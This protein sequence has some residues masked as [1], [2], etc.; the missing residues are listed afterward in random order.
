M[1]V[2]EPERTAEAVRRVLPDLLRLCCYESRAAARRDRAIRG[3][4]Q[5]GLNIKAQSEISRLYRNFC[6]I[7]PISHREIRWLGIRVSR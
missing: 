1:P 4:A 2:R 7:N 6:R 5:S 3:L